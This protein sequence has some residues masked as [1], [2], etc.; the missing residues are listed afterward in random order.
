M[1]AYG[2]VDQL[3]K[4][5][6]QVPDDV[7][8][9]INSA[10][11]L[12]EKDIL[13]YLTHPKDSSV[14][15][16]PPNSAI[17]KFYHDRLDDLACLGL[18]AIS[19][20]EIAYCIF[21]DSP[22][23]LSLLPEINITLFDLKVQQSLGNCPIWVVVN[24]L[25]RHLFEEKVARLPKEVGDRITLLDHFL[26]YKFTPDNLL[27]SGNYLS[28]CGSGDIFPIITTNKDLI[29]NIKHVVVVDIDNIFEIGR[30]HV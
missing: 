7:K 25:H 13:Y 12:H 4:S 10:G 24:P 30:A 11:G 14:T 23:A 3:V 15:S 9:K 22:R 18:D 8:Q 17:V 16:A 26:T 29:K 27:Q 28:C 2:F 1:K 6:D 5:F 20:N 21:A 19:K